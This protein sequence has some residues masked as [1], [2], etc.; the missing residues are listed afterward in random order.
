MMR[1]NNVL[2]E[3]VEKLRKKHKISQEQI[4]SVLGISRPTYAQFVCGARDLTISE[5]KK[6]AEMFNMQ[7]DDLLNEREI[8][9]DLE[10]ENGDCMESGL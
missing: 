9:I 2:A 5:A 4:V 8:V 7:L 1:I 3:F 6:L 10:K